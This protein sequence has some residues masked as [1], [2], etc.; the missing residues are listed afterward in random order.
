MNTRGKKIL[1]LM[2]LAIILL[3][4]PKGAYSE[5]AT[6]LQEQIEDLGNQRTALE[7]EI[8]VYD[9]QLIFLNE[10]IGKTDQEI[11]KNE[12]ELKETEEELRIQNEY[13]A[14][15]L[16]VIYEEGQKSFFE[17][18]FSSHNLSELMDRNEYLDANR[19]RLKQSSDL[20]KE[21]K[22]KAD[23]TKQ[24]LAFLQDLQKVFKASL[25]KQKDE[26][27]VTLAAVTEEERQIRQKFSDRL[28]KFGK[29]PYCRG[30]GSTI[31]AKYPVF[32]FPVECGYISQGFGMTEFAAIDRAYRGKIHNGFDV[33]IAT[34]NR[35]LS[36]GKG[37]VFAK[38][39]TPSGGWGNWVMVKQDKVT[40]EGNE[41]EFYAL[42][43]HLVAE[44]HLKVG[45]PVRGGDVV[46]FVGGTPDWAPHLHFSLFQSASGWQDASPGAYPGNAVDPLNY[47]DI[48]IS[49]G[50]TDWDINYLHV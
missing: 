3:V 42:Y 15:N 14:E 21:L 43:A 35:I 40:V 49:I 5:P 44:T 31:R 36:V 8:G 6:Q 2:F 50:G 46:G 34:G 33:G 47:M 41:Y 20:V 37:I 29:N 28:L 38:G 26:K 16:R 7:T 24:N 18:L 9:Q 19:Q 1:N 32:T 48:P 39:V 12:E 13:L 10:Q 30:Q 23:D 25:E 17:I 4:F 27:L 22:E 45:D 11:V